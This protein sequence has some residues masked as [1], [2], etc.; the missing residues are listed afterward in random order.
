MTDLAAWLLDRIAA[1]EAAARAATPGPW[2]VQN[3]APSLV[4]GHPAR[5]VF[6][7]CT[8]VNGPEARSDAAHIARWDPARVL[9]ECDAKRR[10]VALMEE[11]EWEGGWTL[12][13]SVL[14][15]LASP[16]RSHPDWRDEWDQPFG[17]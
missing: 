1:D 5:G 10:I 15:A 9:A 16:Y 2:A 8:G 11:G 3:G 17:S 4:Y 12:A 14:R 6:V 7:C 13:E